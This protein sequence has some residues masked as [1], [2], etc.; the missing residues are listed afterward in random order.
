M[1][2]ACNFSVNPVA[3]LLECDDFHVEWVKQKKDLPLHCMS[4]CGYL[5]PQ[6]RYSF[7]NLTQW[8]WLSKRFYLFIRNFKFV[9]ATMRSGLPSALASDAKG[10][11]SR[12]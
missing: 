8:F 4:V 12:I 11:V 3:S 6:I 10:S 9:H 5:K 1:H 2:W 7:R